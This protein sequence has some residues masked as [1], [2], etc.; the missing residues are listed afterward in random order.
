M[1]MYKARAK[2]LAIIE[3]ESSKEKSYTP[4]DRAQYSKLTDLQTKFADEYY[5]NKYGKSVIEMQEIEPDK[6]HLKI[7]IGVGKA[8]AKRAE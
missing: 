5:R 2:Q 4:F 7:A 6:N 1:N 3:A 8:L